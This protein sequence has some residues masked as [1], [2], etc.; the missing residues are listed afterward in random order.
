MHVILELAQEGMRKTRLMARAN[1]S[2]QQTASFLD[3]LLRL[4]LLTCDQSLYK[5]TARG[6]GFIESFHQIQEILGEM[7]L[8][9]TQS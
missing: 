5:T 4:Q 2:Y 8:V 3:V 6:R 9:H 1:L 7:P